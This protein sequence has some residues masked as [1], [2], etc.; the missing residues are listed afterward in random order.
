MSDRTKK[1]KK[2]YVVCL[3]LSLLAWVVPPAY[4]VI[5]AFIGSTLL[6]EKVALGLTVL[7][8]AI[9]TMVAMVNKLVLRSRIWIILIGLWIA[10]DSFIT[11]LVI[12]ASAQILDEL[13]LCPLKGYFKS[14]YT[15]NKE[16]DLR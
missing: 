7:I 8:V 10:L 14:R 3:I 16:I 9:M 11:P 6:V 2:W 12:I 15:I 13:V 5:S 1:F 4:Y